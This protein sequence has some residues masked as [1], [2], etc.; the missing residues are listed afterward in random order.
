[1]DYIIYNFMKL[2][3]KI[4]ERLFLG[5]KVHVTYFRVSINIYL[6]HPFHIILRGIVFMFSE[7]N[8]VCHSRSLLSGNDNIAQLR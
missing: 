4:R 8:Q 1:M 3:P 7:L 5:K 2:N 6:R